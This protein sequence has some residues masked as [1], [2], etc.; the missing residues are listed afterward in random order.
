MSLFSAVFPLQKDPVRHLQPR[1]QVRDVQAGGVRQ[2]SV[3]GEWEGRGNDE[4]S[5][6]GAEE[7]HYG[8]FTVIG[9][10]RCAQQ[11]L[12][13]RTMQYACSNRSDCRVIAVLSAR[14]RSRL[15]SHECRCRGS[16]QYSLGLEM[17]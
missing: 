9:V 7:I 11:T 2:M 6:G 16:Y 15:L 3:K 4:G 14:K 8:K 17:N 12:L 10:F 1:L 5:A 13:L